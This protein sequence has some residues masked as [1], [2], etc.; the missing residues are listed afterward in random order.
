MP[1][2]PGLSHAVA[3]WSATFPSMTDSYDVDYL[4]IGAG[5]MGMAFTDVIL[6]ET[7]ASVALVDRRPRPGGHWNDAYPHVRLHQ[8]S[9]FYGVNSRE[10]GTENID[11]YG[12]NKGLSELASG[13]EVVAYFDQVLRQQF[14]ATD[15]VQWFPLHEHQ[16][17]GDIRS[18]ATG[19]VTS[20]S[21]RKVV[22][23]RYMNV[24]VPAV[25]A[26]DYEID[27][28]VTCIPPNGLSRP[29]V[30][31]A[32]SF[33]VIGGGKTGMDACLFL[34]ESG[35]PV[36]DITWIRP[37]DSWCLDRARIQ[38][39]TGFFEMTVGGQAKQMQ[40]IA[41]S[42]DI[43][44]MFERLEAEGLLLRF[45]SEVKPTMYRCATV[46]QA[47]LEALKTVTNVV[48]MG[49][50]QRITSH[51]IVL[52]QGTI[53]TSPGTVHID[54][55]AD[56]LERRPIV[57][58]FDGDRITLQTVRTCQQ[59]F[60]AAFIGHVEAAYDD[61]AQKNELATVVPHPDTDEDWIKVTLGGLLNSARWRGDE[62]LA[63]W[64]IEARL[65]AFSS[66]RFPQGDAI[67]EGHSETMALLEQHALPAVLKLQE[68]AEQLE[69]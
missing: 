42:S 17:G 47:E 43:D 26:P 14:M 65:D 32:E 40:A 3:E 55:S 62:A 19:E 21:A 13:T 63:A 1:P 61:E 67:P 39:G 64:L 58:V 6:T 66:I 4:V 45:D 57:P 8:P 46:S 54:C 28:G 11:A 38:P 33:V 7:D 35:V 41:E 34:I 49:R 50:V 10:L 23:A 44:D 53:P 30:L 25:K 5:A 9:A 31:P 51:E 69:P 29:G 18:I 60:S 68:Y 37:R 15:R 2:A 20:I 16:G 24:T 27:E 52:D 59:V 56:G 36:D 48:R 12:W 22:D